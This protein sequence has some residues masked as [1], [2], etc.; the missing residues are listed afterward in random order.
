MFV[1]EKDIEPVRPPL[2]HRVQRIVVD[3]E[4]CGDDRCDCDLTLRD[5][6]INMRP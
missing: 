6:R 3:E 1:V 4:A 2:Q 5:L